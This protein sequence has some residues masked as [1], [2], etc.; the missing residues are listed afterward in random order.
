MWARVGPVPRLAGESHSER[1][2]PF[3]LPMGTLT[4]KNARLNARGIR[5]KVSSQSPQTRPAAPFNGVLSEQC[6]LLLSGVVVLMLLESIS[7][8]TLVWAYW[9]TGAPQA[10]LVGWLAAVIGVQLIR[11][12][13]LPVCHRKLQSGAIT[14]N[15]RTHVVRPGTQHPPADRPGRLPVQPPGH[16]VHSPIFLAPS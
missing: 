4:N 16:P 12:L 3:L 15:C 10:Y 7:A 1:R 6:Q 8:A 11:L 9:N 2:F 5:I 13:I 14:T